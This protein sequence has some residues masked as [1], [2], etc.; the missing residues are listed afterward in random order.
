[1]GAVNVLWEDLSGNPPDSADAEAWADQ[2]GLTYTVLADTEG[3]WYDTW[4]VPTGA[5]FTTV[6]IDRDGTIVWK[7]IGETA[8]ADDEALAEVEALLAAE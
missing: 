1:M 2:F 3:T 6:V 5:Q 4:V 8:S 7:K